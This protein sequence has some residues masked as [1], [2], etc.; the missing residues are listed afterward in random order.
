MTE[1]V[2]GSPG[3][4]T[5]PHHGKHVLGG[6]SPSFPRGTHG[7]ML[8]VCL[9]GTWDYP[10]SSECIGSGSELPLIRRGL[11]CHYERL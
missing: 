10:G 9:L 7:H 11:R 1:E 4:R 6:P 5:V 2:A 8:G 3:R